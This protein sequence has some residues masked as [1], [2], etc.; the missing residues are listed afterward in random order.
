MQTFPKLDTPNRISSLFYPR[1][2]EVTPLPEGA[3]DLEIETEPGV[4]IG[5]KQV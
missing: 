2:S 1:R 5:Y 4:S 3:I